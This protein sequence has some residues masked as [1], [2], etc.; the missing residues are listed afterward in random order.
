MLMDLVFSLDSV[1][2]AVG[3]A[4]A[5]SVMVVAVLISVGIMLALAEGI[6]TFVSK[7]PTVKTLALA[8][9]LLIGVMLTAEGVHLH[10]IEKGSSHND[11]RNAFAMGF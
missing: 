3:M 7:N 8:F 6:S 2:T 5:L 9:L 11:L 1:I 10:H 4:D